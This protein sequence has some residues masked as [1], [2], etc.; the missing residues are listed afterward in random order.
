MQMD[1][2]QLKVLLSQEPT[3]VINRIHLYTQKPPQLRWFFIFKANYY[4]NLPMYYKTN[5]MRL[6]IILS[7][8]FL[9]FNIFS[10]NT[11]GI[12]TNEAESYNAYTLFAPIHSTETYLI[13]NCGEVLHQWSSS[14]SPA[15]SVYLLPNG[16]LF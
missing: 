13:N 7:I 9:S 15:A 11:V 4:L 6:C 2:Y 10:Q 5:I 12:I 8:L 3:V 16:N 1:L 14:N